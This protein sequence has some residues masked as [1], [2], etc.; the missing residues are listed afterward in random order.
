[1]GEKTNFSLNC[2]KKPRFT[3]CKINKI[4]YNLKSKKT[5]IGFKANLIAS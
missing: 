2:S 1:M 4:D 5:Y 3:V